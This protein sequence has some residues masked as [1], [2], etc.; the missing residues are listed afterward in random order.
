MKVIHGIMVNDEGMIEEIGKSV[1][2]FVSLLSMLRRGGEGGGWNKEESWGDES[3]GYS[4]KQ[5]GRNDSSRQL[6]SSR[7]SSRASRKRNLKY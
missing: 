4:G 2:R 6:K 3:Q 5:A 1:H 7:I